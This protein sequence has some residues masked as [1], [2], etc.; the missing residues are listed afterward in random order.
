MKIKLLAVFFLLATSQIA[1]PQAGGYLFSQALGTYT[2][3]SGT[4]VLSNCTNNNQNT[5]TSALVTL[6]QTFTFCGVLYNEIRVG[7]NGWI[8]FGSINP[9]LADNEFYQSALSN[10]GGTPGVIQPLYTGWQI[11]ANGAVP[12]DA[13]VQTA[14]VG[15]EYVVQW[16]NGLY[17]WAVFGFGS[18]TFWQIDMQVR[19]NF[20]DN[21]IKIIYGGFESANCSAPS[22]ATVC[23]G[24]LV[25]V[26]IKSNGAD[27]AEHQN[28]RYV[29]K[30]ASLDAVNP[31]PFTQSIRG[32]GCYVHDARSIPVGTT[33]IWLPGTLFPPAAY[34][35]SSVE[36]NTATIKW[37]RVA[38]ADSYEYN[39]RKQ[40][41]SFT[42]PET[43]TIVTDTAVNISGLQPDTVYQL[44]VRSRN[45]AYVSA[46]RYF[47]AVFK[48]PCTA[49]SL[50]YV[51]DFTD[52]ACMK[53]IKDSATG[54]GWG[55][56][57]L[58]NEFGSAATPVGSWMFSRRLP[59]NA[60]TTT[61]FIL[62]TQV[63]LLVAEHLTII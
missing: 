19:L 26:G 49:T 40:T 37:N 60:G 25:S 38:A 53:V 29:P 2:P 32:S 39:I 3:V 46:W 14:V 6:P 22:F 21:S 44:A 58:V 17:R 11:P 62:N 41:S 16:T 35:A 12:C 1:K 48:T 31:I 36:A 20:T 27:V 43:G 7:K 63:I 28:A 55:G 59:L 51:A 33:F 56:G 18:E 24:A 4:V 57:N 54:I 47:D 61:G 5:D 15:N 42:W 30:G 52:V 45:G 50:P 9:L 13:N 34:T 10:T 8:T 23:Q